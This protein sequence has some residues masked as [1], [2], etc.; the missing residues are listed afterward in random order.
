M[1]LA[2]YDTRILSLKAALA[3]SV[4][5]KLQCTK[6]KL[7]KTYYIRGECER[8]LFAYLSNIT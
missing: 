2:E 3:N 8:D 4:L 6:K 7:N 5:Q 1:K